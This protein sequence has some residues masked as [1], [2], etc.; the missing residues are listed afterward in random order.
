MIIDPSPSRGF[1][2]CSEKVMEQRIK[3]KKK[4]TALMILPEFI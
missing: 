2:S 1:V 4:K 3:A